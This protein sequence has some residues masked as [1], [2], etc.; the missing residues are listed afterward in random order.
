MTIRQKGKMDN[1]LQILNQP[2]ITTLLSL[3]IGGYLLK[4][5]SDHRAH[6][7]S[8]REKSIELINEVGEN[9]NNVMGRIFGYIRRGDFSN[10][11]QDDDLNSKLGKL[12]T[13]RLN[14]E[15]KSQAYL[16]SKDFS[17]KYESLVFEFK[18]ISMYMDKLS[19]GTDKKKINSEVLRHMQSLS[20]NWPIEKERSFTDDVKPEYKELAEWTTMVSRRVSW[21][22]SF[23]LSKALK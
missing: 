18:E 8:I 11:A 5:I 21:L 23:Y 15:I 9:F 16:R 17:K 12:F 1:I 7:D 2:I 6:K 10:I 4:L 22:L 3:S 14:V 13:N 20:D 19:K